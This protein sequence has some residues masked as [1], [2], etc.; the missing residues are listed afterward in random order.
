[1]DLCSGVN[2]CS[3]V[4]LSLEATMWPIDKG[5]ANEGRRTP[6]AAKENTLPLTT[7]QWMENP[8]A[9]S[10]LGVGQALG[11]PSPLSALPRAILYARS[12]KIEIF[13]GKP[14]LG[15]P[16]AFGSVLPSQCPGI[17]PM[18]SFRYSRH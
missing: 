3:G 4:V 16:F 9:K 13:R 18:H 6:A 1:M 2:F 12:T 10:F 5:P 17:H 7:S 14:Y 11:H 15:W 8:A